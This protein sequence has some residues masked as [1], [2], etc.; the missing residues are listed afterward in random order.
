[1]AFT[2]FNYDECR[3][4]KRLQQSTDVGNYH[5][6]VPGNGTTPFFIEDPNIRIQKWGGNLRTNMV[7]IDSSLKGIDKQLKCDSM[8][9]NPKPVQSSAISYPS[10]RLLYTEQSRTI[11][12]AW[13]LRGLETPKSE[14]LHYN[15][16]IK[17]NIP[18]MHNISSRD[19]EK[20]LYVPIYKDSFMSLNI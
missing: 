8:R 6:N 1:M 7:D 20:D 2:R 15:P 12:P 17:A 10:T 11:Q 14:Y 13:N 4:K 18:F 16:Q 19:I 9:N 3:T 5:L